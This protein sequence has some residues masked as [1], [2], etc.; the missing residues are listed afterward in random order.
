MT[1]FKVGDRVVHF[2]GRATER[3]GTVYMILGGEKDIQQFNGLFYV[4]WDD[5]MRGAYHPKLLRL[6]DSRYDTRLLSTDPNRTF[7]IDKNRKID[8]SSDR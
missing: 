8:R 7:S 2:P 1:T 3:Y 6:Y 5:G 4:K